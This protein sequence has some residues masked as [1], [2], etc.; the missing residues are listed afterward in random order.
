MVAFRLLLVALVAGCSAEMEAALSA[1]D[2]AESDGE[3]S[4]TG[5]GDADSGLLADPVWWKL[6][7]T[8]LVATDGSVDP[9]GSTLDLQLMDVDGVSLCDEALLLS[10][11]GEALA[12]P[13]ESV[14]GWWRLEAAP[15]EGSCASWPSPVPSPVLLGVGAMDPDVY[16]LLGTLGLPEGAADDLNGAYASIDQ[17]STLWVYGAAGMAAAFDGDGTAAGEVPVQDGPW[18]LEPLFTFPYNR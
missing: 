8:L 14:Y 11:G 16:A 6:G 18:M 3:G 12:V 13:H 1:T 15:P 9:E 7:G 10:G 2:V 4:D 17:G 5:G